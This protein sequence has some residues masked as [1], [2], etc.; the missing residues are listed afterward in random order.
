MGEGPWWIPIEGPGRLAT[1]ARPRGGDALGESLRALADRG[2][3]GF[4]SLL[5]QP[6][7][8]ALGLGREDATCREQGLSFRRLRVPDFGIPADEGAF[9]SLAR[10]LREDLSSG[11]TIVI[12]CH[13][14]IGRSSLLAAAVLTL[15]GQSS[16][17]ALAAVQLARGVPVPDSQAQRVWLVDSSG[18]P[19][20]CS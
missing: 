10:E 8:E 15:G 9:W 16:T 17:E 7:E 14:G 1:S 19:G 6:E 3:D 5:S 20:R 18:R 13:A 12:H 4:V 11:S 2:V